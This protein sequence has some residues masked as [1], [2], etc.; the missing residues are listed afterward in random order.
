MPHRIIKNMLDKEFQYFID[1]QDELVKKYN[2]RFIVIKDEAVIG[3]YSTNLEAYN[4]TSKTHP[5]GTFL[6]QHCL[7]GKDAYTITFHSRVYNKPS[8]AA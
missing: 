6:I 8:N 1:H 2:G 7:P 5:V 3:D 4:E